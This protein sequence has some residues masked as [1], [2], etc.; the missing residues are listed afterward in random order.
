[1]V[2]LTVDLYGS[3]L[4]PNLRGSPTYS[5]TIPCLLEVFVL[6]QGRFWRC[7]HSDIH[8]AAGTMVMNHL[9]FIKLRKDINNPQIPVPFRLAADPNALPDVVRDRAVGDQSLVLLRDLEA[10]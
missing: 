9:Y 1:M 10:L 2:G 7:V 3:F 5:E 8:A 4:F 6:S